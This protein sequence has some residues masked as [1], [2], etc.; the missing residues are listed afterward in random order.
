[1]APRSL[2]TR[3]CPRCSHRWLAI[4][5]SRLFFGEWAQRDELAQIG[6]EMLVC[7]YPCCG[8]MERLDGTPLGRRAVA[9][10]E[11]SPDAL[12]K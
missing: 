10:D 2:K 1:M 3:P 5:P 12:Q 8:M 7:T 6:E 4:W 11:T 9:G